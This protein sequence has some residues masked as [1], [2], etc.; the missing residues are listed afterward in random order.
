MTQAETS[1]D[2]ALRFLLGRIDYERAW[3]VPYRGRGFKLDR[4][5]EL[6]DRLGN[7]QDRLPILHVAGTKGKGSTAAMLAAV[8]AAAGYR[9]GMFS[10]PHFERVE[11]RVAV[12]GQPCSAAELTEGVEEIRPAI[13]TMDR[14]AVAAG[15]IGPTYFEIVTALAL[16]HFLRRQ[17]DAAV[18][19][20]GLGG[21]L[22]STNVCTPRVCIITSVSFDHTEQLGDTLEAIA[23]EKA[24]IVK[25]GVPVVSGVQ[26]SEARRVVVE[27]CRRRGAALGELGVDFTF[28]YRP[29]PDLAQSDAPARLDFRR[30]RPVAG[31]AAPAE[32]LD[33]ALPLPGRHQAANATLALAA[34]APLQRG[35]WRIDEASVRRGLAALRWPG[36]MEVARRRPAVVLD[37]AHNVASIKALLATLDESFRAA[38]RH[39]I[40]A[41]SNDKDTRGML[42]AL[43][44]RFDTVAITRYVTNP[45]ST[46]PEELAKLAYELAGRRPSVFSTPA[47]AWA[48]VE[49][50]AE[51]EDLICATGSFFIAA[52]MR[53][54]LAA[55]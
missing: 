26:A 41:A 45:R 22:D 35:G 38:R 9:T 13:D 4:M 10:S 5:R 20:V 53:R 50:L 55:V 12:D 52:E 3:S 43:L 6:L 44:G 1:Y 54:L 23:R 11:E 40:F 51:R 31:D 18:L 21:R 19:E 30:L 28:A 34:L 17:V 24:G 16:V 32:Y 8:L 29:A 47:A 49:A 25:P 14:A 37:V 48:S 36:R 15:E 27:V 46:P 42:Q 7:P 33:L 39:L 2:A